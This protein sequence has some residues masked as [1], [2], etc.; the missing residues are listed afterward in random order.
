M[1]K[2]TIFKKVKD[3]YQK[4]FESFNDMENQKERD[5]EDVSTEKKRR[6][7]LERKKFF[8]ERT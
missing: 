5:N 7:E 2:I 8:I 6:K 3:F 1:E 4:H